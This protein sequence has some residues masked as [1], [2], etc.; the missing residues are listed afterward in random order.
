MKTLHFEKYIG[1]AI[2]ASLLFACQT[3][4]VA[5][6]EPVVEDRIDLEAMPEFEFYTLDD[7]KFSSSQL[8][9]EKQKVFYYFD[10]RCEYCDEQ[11]K[12]MKVFAN[13]KDNVQVVMVTPIGGKASEDYFD[14]YRLDRH[15]N[16]LYLWDKEDTFD[17]LFSVSAFPYILVFD[18]DNQYVNSYKGLTP[19]SVLYATVN[20]IAR[21]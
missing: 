7:T 9:P 20:E 13:Q 14:T 3:R 18:K 6:D 4:T 12:W 15:D 16:L 21:K 2:V 10:P 17:E 11:T 8:D 19:N 5:P 1:L